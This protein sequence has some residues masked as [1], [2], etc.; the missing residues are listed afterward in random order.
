M[1]PDPAPLRGQGSL[2]AGEEDEVI[3]NDPVGLDRRSCLKIIIAHRNCRAKTRRTD[4][5]RLSLSIAQ[6]HGTH[7]EDDLLR[8]P[9]P[10]QR[11]NVPTFKRSH[12]QIML[13]VGASPRRSSC[14]APSRIP[15]YSG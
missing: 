9:V 1:L 12:S 7:R 5:P 2:V 13:A 10:L 4:L 8:A 15:G 6:R 11:S 14:G 3:V